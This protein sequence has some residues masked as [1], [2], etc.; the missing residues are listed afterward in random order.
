VA[1]QKEV[2][3]LKDLVG[4]STVA[5]KGKPVFDLVAMATNAKK[6]LVTRLNWREGD[7]NR[8]RQGP[9]EILFEG[10]MSDLNR[11]EHTRLK[12]AQTRVLKL[13][14]PAVFSY[15]VLSRPFAQTQMSD[16]DSLSKSI[17]D[18]LKKPSDLTSKERIDT[19]LSIM[20]FCLRLSVSQRFDVEQSKAAA[21]QS[22]DLK[23]V[24]Q[25]LEGVLKDGPRQN[26][27]DAARDVLNIINPLLSPSSSSNEGLMG[28]GLY[29]AKYSMKKSDTVKFLESKYWP[30]SLG[31][32]RKD[33]L[34]SDL[35]EALIDA[36]CPPA[37]RGDQV[38]N[39]LVDFRS[40]MNYPA[41]QKEN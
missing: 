13:Q 34:C 33:I 1:C 36:V 16:M 38:E 4:L 17:K 31:F 22:A 10:K 9:Q 12:Q 28:Q 32:N 5:K 3:E 11:W 23:E 18:S 26:V 39:R 8:L 20:H 19:M 30:S 7:P 24:R 41:P 15:S 6:E 29:W 21:A 35:F 14:V 2:D 27:P 37:Y 25:V 40:R